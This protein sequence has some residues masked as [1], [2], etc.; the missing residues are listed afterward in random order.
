MIMQITQTV[1]HLQENYKYALN[2]LLLIGLTFDGLSIED[3]KKIFQDKD[4]VAI[5]IEQLEVTSLVEL[6]QEIRTYK[7]QNFIMKYVEFRF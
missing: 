3:L 4:D 5:V 6:D 2:M 7:V 1:Q